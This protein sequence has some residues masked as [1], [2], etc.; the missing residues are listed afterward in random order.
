MSN[1]AKTMYAIDLNEAADMIEAGGKKRTV[2][3]QGPMGSG[4]SSVL[5][6]LADRMPTHT[7]CYVDCT[8]K[9]LG[10]LTIPNV[11]MLDDETGCVRYVPN[12]ELG[13][14][15]NKTDHHDGRRVR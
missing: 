3:L 7:P 14:H 15:L 13:L 11:M 1:Q 10:D 12:E 9:D 2:L 4:K 8:T 5:W 6:T